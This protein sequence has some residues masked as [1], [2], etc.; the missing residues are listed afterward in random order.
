MHTGYRAYS[1]ELADGRSRSC[2]TRRTSSSTPRCS[3]RRCT[4]ASASPRCRARTIYSEEASSIGLRPSIVYGLKTL[5]HAARAARC[6]ARGI[7]RVAGS[8]SRESPASASSR[9]EGGFNPTWQRHVAAYRAVRAAAA[10]TGRVLDLGCGV[11]HSFHAARPAR[12]RRRRPRPRRRSPARTARRTSPT[13]ARCRSRDGA[14]A[15][16]LSVQ[17][18]EHVPDP[19]RV[20]AR[21]AR[22]CSRP[23]AS[24]SSSRPTG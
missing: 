17:S 10:A 1:R 18:L 11:G 8:S 2:A 15:A 16:V 14:F 21:G 19:Q 24:R 22:A 3:C 13:C 23:A 9:R 7:W 20:V 5:A 12:D 4:S 6:T